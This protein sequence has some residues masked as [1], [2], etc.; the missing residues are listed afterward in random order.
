M[1]RKI[2]KNITWIQFSDLHI[3]DSTDW[4]LMLDGYRKLSERIHPDFIVVTGDYRHKNYDDNKDYSKTL[5]FLEKIV[6]LFNIK[7]EDV[8]LVPGNHDV[9]DYEFREECINQIKEKID[10]DPDVYQKYLNTSNN[11]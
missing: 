5:S 8:F 7:K 4:N 6:S 10:Q 3:F 1:E 11:L 2:K 9:E